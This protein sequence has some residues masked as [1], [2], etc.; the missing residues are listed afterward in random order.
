MGYPESLRT[1]VS[2][3][4][5]KLVQANIAGQQRTK[6]IF[7]GH[8]LGGLMIKAAL[9]YS[10]RSANPAERRLV[11]RCAGVAFLG[12]PHGGS[13][14]IS[15]L[16]NFPGLMGDAGKLAG[17]L[18]GIAGAPLLGSVINGAAALVKWFTEPSNQVKWLE[19]AGAETVVMGSLAYGAPD[20]AA[21]IQWL[22][23]LK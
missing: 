6:V 14:L 22:H 5:Q 18:S 3:L 12:T 7:I 20:L 8:S 10:E 11:E 23:G 1:G 17:V 2:P 9:D 16:A 21:R 4:V 13:G 19:K 15:L